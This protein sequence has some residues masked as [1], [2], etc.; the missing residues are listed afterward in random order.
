[1]LVTAIEGVVENG[2]IRLRE[3]VSLAENTRVYVIV[4]GTSTAP[5]TQ[6]HSPRLANPDQAADFRKQIV[7]LPPDAQL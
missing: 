2:T 7:E 5:A 1:M 6:I 3:P 4:T